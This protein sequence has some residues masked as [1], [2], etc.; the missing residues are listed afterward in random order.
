MMI[1]AGCE[2]GHCHHDPEGRRLCRFLDHFQLY[3]TRGENNDDGCVAQKPNNEEKVLSVEARKI[4]ML[5]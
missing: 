3:P 5:E 2:H 1:A 4:A